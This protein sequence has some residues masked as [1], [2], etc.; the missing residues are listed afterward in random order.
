MAETKNKNLP[1]QGPN[2]A[3]MDLASM[4]VIV[5]G[6]VYTLFPWGVFQTRLHN[7][8]I[9]LMATPVFILISALIAFTGT[10][11]RR[12]TESPASPF[13]LSLTLRLLIWGSIIGLIGPIAFRFI[14]LLIAG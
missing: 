8:D 6:I 10:V 1:Q 11:L 3:V 5:A 9:M 2:W 4:V 13:G 12:K 7:V 14:G